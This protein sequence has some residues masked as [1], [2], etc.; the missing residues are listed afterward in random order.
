MAPYKNGIS[1]NSISQLTLLVF[2]KYYQRSVNRTPTDTIE[3]RKLI[4]ISPWFGKNSILKFH[5]N[6]FES[7]SKFEHF[8]SKINRSAQPLANNLWAIFCKVYHFCKAPYFM[9]ARF[10]YFRWSICHVPSFVRY[11]YFHMALR[12]SYFAGCRFCWVYL[13][14]GGVVFAFY[15]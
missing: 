4:G 14:S 13:I 6:E 10:V 9:G 7:Y 2:L 15:S 5:N 8:F 11:H 12:G 1:K 3:D